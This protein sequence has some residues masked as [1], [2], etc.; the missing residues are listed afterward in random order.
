MGVFSANIV[1]SRTNYLYLKNDQFVLINIIEKS[2]VRYTL[3]LNFDT[4]L[5]LFGKVQ[6]QP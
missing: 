4:L 5:N 1:N 3:S 6:K 2:A